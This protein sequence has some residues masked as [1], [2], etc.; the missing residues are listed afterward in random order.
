MVLVKSVM[1]VQVVL[2]D[3][4]HCQCRDIETQYL[5]LTPRSKPLTEIS[6]DHL[7]LCAR[8]PVVVISAATFSDGGDVY[9]E[10]MSS[11]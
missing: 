10:V 5:R 6:S 1:F 8:T 9:V 2:S 11:T 3:T 7:N 4:Y